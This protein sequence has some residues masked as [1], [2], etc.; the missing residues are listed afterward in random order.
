MQFQINNVV[1]NGTLSLRAIR[2]IR[3]YVSLSVLKSLV[4]M[5]VISRIDFVNGMYTT[6]TK[7]D[8]HRLEVLLNNAA[9]LIT[10]TSLFVS[11]TPV[12]Y[13]L[14]WLKVT[15]KIKYKCCLYVHTI[16]TYRFI[17]KICL[18]YMRQLVSLGFQMTLLGWLYQSLKLNEAKSVSRY[19]L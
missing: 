19:Q 17:S 7:F 15:Y 11:I 12:L 2:R 13:D 6:L 5:L 8:I 3:K 18:S 10:F 1:K 16:L 14:H 4:V 9:R